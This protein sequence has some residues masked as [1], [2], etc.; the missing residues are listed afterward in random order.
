MSAATSPPPKSDSKDWPL[1]WFAR[2]EAALEIGD[3]EEAATAQR[4][5]GRLGVRVE[6]VAPWQSGGLDRAD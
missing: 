5:L 2:F 4:E 6:P 3:L 1:F